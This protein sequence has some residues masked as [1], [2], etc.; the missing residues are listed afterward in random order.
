MM[1]EHKAVNRNR[2]I[3]NISMYNKNCTLK[4]WPRELWRKLYSW[5]ALSTG[6]KVRAYLHI[7]TERGKLKMLSRVPIGYQ[8]AC[9]SLCPINN[10][11]KYK[12]SFF[13]FQNMILQCIL[14]ILILHLSFRHFQSLFFFF[15]S[16]LY[17][18][19]ISFL[20]F[21]NLLGSGTHTPTRHCN[22]NN[23]GR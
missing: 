8:Y 3:Y 4:M 20:Y 6:R 1:H 17:P 9:T 12:F 21:F 18:F 11:L 15:Y 16:I 19:L 2:Y 10:H 7:H 5:R 13:S 14:F 22:I 23:T